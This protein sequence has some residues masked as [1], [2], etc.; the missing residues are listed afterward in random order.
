MIH[1]VSLMRCHNPAKEETGRGEQLQLH[2]DDAVG[3]IRSDQ[4]SNP[5]LLPGTVHHGA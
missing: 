3:P 1:T 4:I 2:D 5:T